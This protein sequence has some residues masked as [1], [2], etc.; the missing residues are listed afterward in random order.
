MARKSR[1]HLADTIV[2]PTPARAGYKAAA[3]IRLSCDDT[4]KRRDSIETQ[5]N[6]I[7]NYVAA[8]PDICLAEI[9]SVY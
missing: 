7:E 8:S 5:R 9:G 6:I 2:A 4:K 3:Y 1:K